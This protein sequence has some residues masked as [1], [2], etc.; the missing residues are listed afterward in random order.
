MNTS[1]KSFIGIDVSKPYFDASLLSEVNHEKQCIKTER[2]SNDPEGI[3]AFGKWLKDH[4]VTFDANTLIVIENT[5]IYHR[6][7]WTFCTKKKLQLHIGNAAHIKW[8]FGIARGKNDIIDSIRLCNYAHK[9]CDELKAAPALNPV[10]LKLK[11]L[12]TSRTKLLT[13]VT[14]IKVY[15]K[16]L[17]N[18]SDKDVQKLLARAHKSAIEGLT[19]SIKSI[20]AELRKIVAEN[21]EVKKNYDLLTTVPGI[22]HLTS[23][24]II[25]CTDNFAGKIKGKQL[26][27]YAGVVPFE[28]S[29]G[30]SIKG[31]NRVHH[32]AN[33]TLKKM[34]HLSA[35]TAIQKYDEFKTYYTR[36]KAEGKHGMS[37]MNAIRNKIILRAVAVVNNQKPYVNRMAVEI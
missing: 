5:G 21:E 31:R 12:M 4:H 33:K 14:A 2:F 30:I 36:K 19:A 11:D 32:M 1:V 17:S 18:V 7:L 8:S 16:E 34:L 13:Q 20:E 6:L 15:I 35:M 25:C 22:G 28:H 3:K 10:L 24:Y 27:C 37:V 9:H 23:I 29:S 26:A